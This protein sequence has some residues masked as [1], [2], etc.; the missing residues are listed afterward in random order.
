ME[1]DRPLLKMLE[2]ATM[3]ATQAV[4]RLTQI[5]CKSTVLGSMKR[6]SNPKTLQI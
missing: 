5:G 2:V 6:T 3:A 1:M 4:K